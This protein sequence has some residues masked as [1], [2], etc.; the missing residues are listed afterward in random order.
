MILIIEQKEE[1]KI[2]KV[3]LSKKGNMTIKKK[4]YNYQ[5]EE[6]V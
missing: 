3:W 1:K 2:K 5:K 6:Y 4:R